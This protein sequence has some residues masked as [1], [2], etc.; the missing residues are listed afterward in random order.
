MHG[1]RII[2]RVAPA[3]NPP[4]GSGQGQ[5]LCVDPRPRVPGPTPY[6]DMPTATPGPRRR[7]AAP[8][9]LRPIEPR[10]R[11]TS[12]GHGKAGETVGRVT[13]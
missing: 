3:L 11:K 6:P 13:R 7:S 12:D 5:A 4:V 10:H 9:P 8:S 1:D 2:L